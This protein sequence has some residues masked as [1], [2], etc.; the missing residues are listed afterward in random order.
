MAWLRGSDVWNNGMPGAP[1]AKKKN[2]LGYICKLFNKKIHRLRTSRWTVVP[3]LA[4]VFML[5][6]SGAGLA[7][8][9]LEPDK[10][11]GLEWP[12][13][14]FALSLYAADDETD[15]WTSHTLSYI[16]VEAGRQ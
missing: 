14:P 7:V 10:A 4:Q 11:A 16:F 13:A 3:L 9:D 1:L 6:F 12:L 2:K 15:S 5:G 8:I